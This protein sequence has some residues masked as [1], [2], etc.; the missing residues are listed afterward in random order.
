[1][2][3]EL[4]AEYADLKKQIADLEEIAESKRMQISA[5]ME[6]EGADKVESD[7]GTF[8]FTTRKTWQY[9]PV[10]DA[11]VEGL[12]VLKKKE[13]ES[14]AAKATESKSLTFKPTK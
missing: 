8:F 13:E 6:K 4:F 10:V 3:K 2:K 11:A 5:E 9:S 7:F 14:G 12:K 1:M